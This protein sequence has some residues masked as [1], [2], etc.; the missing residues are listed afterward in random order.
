MIDVDPSLHALAIREFTTGEYLPEGSWWSGTP[1][2]KLA[3]DHVASSRGGMHHPCIR[4]PRD[5]IATHGTEC[6]HIMS[7]RAR[8]APV[9]SLVYRGKEVDAMQNSTATQD[10]DTAPGTPVERTE[11]SRTILV[12][13]HD[14]RCYI[15][16]PPLRLSNGD[17]LMIVQCIAERYRVC[18]DRHFRALPP[19]KCDPGTGVNGTHAETGAPMRGN[20]PVLFCTLKVVDVVG[21]NHEDSPR[22]RVAH[23]QALG[24]QW[25]CHAERESDATGLAHRRGFMW[26]GDATRAHVVDLLKLRGE[27]RHEMQS[28]VIL[29][30]DPYRQIHIP[31]EEVVRFVHQTNRSVAPLDL[32]WESIDSSGSGA[33]AGSSQGSRMP[34]FRSESAGFIANLVSPGASPI[35]GALDR[36]ALS[37]PASPAPVRSPN[38][39]PCSPRGSGRWYPSS[40][41]LDEAVEPVPA[42]IPASNLPPPAA[43]ALNTVYYGNHTLQGGS[44]PVAPPPHPTRPKIPKERGDGSRLIPV[45]PHATPAP[46]P[47]QKT[48]RAVERRQLRVE[49]GEGGAEPADPP[50]PPPSPPNR[51]P[52]SARRSSVMLS[53]QVVPGAPPALSLLPGAGG[54]TY[55]HPKQEESEN[56]A[57][58]PCEFAGKARTVKISRR[59]GGAHYTQEHSEAVAGGDSGAADAPTAPVTVV[60]AAGR[61]PSTGRGKKNPSSPDEK[62]HSRGRPPFYASPSS[63]PP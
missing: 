5:Y 41:S 13:H 45:P 21:V 61:P 46:Q 6:R 54:S 55:P 8:G 16:K 40:S 34:I 32:D 60:G 38:S 36:L 24:R 35:A 25:S 20:D 30:P 59:G 4:D 22:S 2:L 53:P 3:D 26:C 62:R 39:L 37:M 27:M 47:P 50:F 11:R 17:P 57:P 51:G 56:P 63:S 23:M 19:E 7:W 12:S 15:V 44:T 49:I 18:D 28:I 33:S 43:R 14:R 9:F 10:Q 42:S 58:G 31:V 48:A 29:T 1:I 52:K